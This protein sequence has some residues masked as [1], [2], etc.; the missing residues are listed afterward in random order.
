[1]SK[2][3]HWKNK[4]STIFLF[5]SF[6]REE[7][8]NYFKRKKENYLNF[9][10]H[11]ICYPQLSNL[12]EYSISI[13]FQPKFNAPSTILSLHLSVSLPYSYM[14][15]PPRESKLFLQLKLL[16][17]KNMKSFFCCCCLCLVIF[18]SA[19]ISLNKKKTWFKFMLA[20]FYVL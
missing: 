5:Y 20:F 16:F 7:N 8:K 10:F 15:K 6:V 17:E 12:A 1:M 9:L 3:Q 2:K 13:L 4:S 11:K 18:T 19:G 14:L